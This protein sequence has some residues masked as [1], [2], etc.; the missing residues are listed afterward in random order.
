MVVGIPRGTKFPVHERPLLF[1][2]RQESKGT[3]MHDYSEEYVDSENNLRLSHL[4][5]KDV[6]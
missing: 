2:R 1:Q 6:L 5:Q 4:Y 3:R